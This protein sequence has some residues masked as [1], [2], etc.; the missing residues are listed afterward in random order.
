MK[1]F[2]H[3]V[4]EQLPQTEASGGAGSF[5]NSDTVSCNYVGNL[6]VVHRGL[7]VCH[8]YVDYLKV[9]RCVLRWI[10]AHVCSPLY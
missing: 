9:T 8:K 10:V 4:L 2:L 7:N 3:A 5:D 1:V 6:R